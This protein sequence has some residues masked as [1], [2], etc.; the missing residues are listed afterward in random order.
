MARSARVLRAQRRIGRPTISRAGCAS[1]SRRRQLKAKTRGRVS[2]VRV[3]AVLAAA[4]AAAAEELT[5]P[6]L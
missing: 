2:L 4:A 3:V 5:G 1:Q 6:N